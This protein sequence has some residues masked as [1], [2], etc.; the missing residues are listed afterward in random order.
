MKP[1]A[2]ILFS[3]LISSYA[4]SQPGS[5]DNSFGT[6]GVTIKDIQND[7]YDELH[8]IAIQADGKIIVVGYAKNYGFILRYSAAGLLDSSFGKNGMVKVFFKAGFDE[9]IINAVA[10]QTDG[11]IVVTGGGYK[12]AYPKFD[13]SVARF[14]ADGKPDSSFGN[15][16]ITITNIDSSNGQ[17]NAVVIQKN[18]KIVITGTTNKGNAYAL[19]VVRYNTDGKIDESFGASGI[20]TLY[21]SGFLIMSNVSCTINDD[22]KIIAAGSLHTVQN[23]ANDIFLFR[24]NG[25][26]TP[27]S[28]FGTNG[29][30]TTGFSGNDENASAIYSLKKNKLLVCASIMNENTRSD[31]AVIKFNDD[32]TTDKSFGKNGIAKAHFGGNDQNDFAYDMA[33]QSNGQIIVGGYSYNIPRQY[34]LLALARFNSNG[35]IDTSFGRQG[36]ST[37]PTAYKNS[38]A[39][40]LAIQSGNKV[41]AGG[42]IQLKGKNYFD[43]LLSRFDLNITVA[44]AAASPFMQIKIISAEQ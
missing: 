37:L 16:G 18:G 26:G 41:I 40:T 12:Y 19:A 4:F 11:K 14:F 3:L 28:S 7:S 9:N 15:N 25:N 38:Q 34:A 33:V 22:G 43:V 30:V 8:D 35:D 13:F 39:S 5:L 24:F 1:T 42:F 17:S 44:K 10:I 36:I 27:D 23:P 32:G 2:F 29:Q 21:R 20:A 31:F 6:N